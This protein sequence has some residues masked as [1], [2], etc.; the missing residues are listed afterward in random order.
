M[1]RAKAVA[2]ALVVLGV[3]VCG[4]AVQSGDKK[5]RTVEVVA[6]NFAF[7]PEKIEAKPGET[8]QVKL[9][10]RGK[11]PHNIEFELPDKEVELD[12]PLKP[13]E[14]GTLTFQAPRKAGKYLFYCPV[15]NHKE[16]GMKGYLFVGKKE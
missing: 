7:K 9:I 16:K 13:G 1:S 14:T 6:V 5:G 15:G 11:A 10:N 8:L 2:P 12:K 3:L 4:S